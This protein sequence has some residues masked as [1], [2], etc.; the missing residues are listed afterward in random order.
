MIVVTLHCGYDKPFE[1]SLPEDIKIDLEK[2]GATV[3]T[4]SHALSGIE[5]SISEK[6][7]GIYP[8]LLIG[9]TLK[10]FG[11]GMKVVAEIA[12]MASD[13]GC[14]SGKDI[15]SIGGTNDGADT[16]V[17]LK[18]AHQNN[19]FHMRIREIICKPRKF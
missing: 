3:V 15:V 11:Q 7:S 1:S 5:R 14:L 16:A 18:P 8:V 19:F 10:L 12:V 9:D 13:A 17:I 4:S 6:H 2:K